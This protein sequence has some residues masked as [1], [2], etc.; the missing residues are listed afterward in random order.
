MGQVTRTLP[1]CDG[2]DLVV[3]DPALLSQHNVSIDF[4]GCSELRA[5]TRIATSRTGF[6]SEGEKESAF[7]SSQIG[8]PN[9]GSCSHGFHGPINA[10]FSLMLLNPWKFFAMPARMSS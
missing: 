4:I 7:V 9:C 8:V 5:V 2:S 3:G 6:G 10:P 1:G